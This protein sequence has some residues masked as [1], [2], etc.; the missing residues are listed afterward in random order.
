MIYNE[1][2]MCAIN[3]Y[4]DLMRLK[5]ESCQNDPSAHCELFNT[6]VLCDPNGVFFAWAR[7]RC[8]DHCGLCPGWCYPFN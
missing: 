5:I 7:S 2:F 4:Y 3:L 8:P 6:T 1:S